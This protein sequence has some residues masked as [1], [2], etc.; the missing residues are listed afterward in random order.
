MREPIF[1]YPNNIAPCPKCG[2]KPKIKVFGVNYARIQCKPMLRKAHLS[3]YTGYQ[4]PSKLMDEAK[5]SW[6]DAADCANLPVW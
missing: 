3:V 2:R 5:K 4:Q 1:E 6:N